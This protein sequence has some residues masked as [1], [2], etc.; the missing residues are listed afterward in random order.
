MKV[1]QYAKK[2]IIRYMIAVLVLSTWAYLTGIVAEAQAPAGHAARSAMDRVVPSKKVAAGQANPPLAERATDRDEGAVPVP[3]VV[4]LQ[5][6]ASA[7]QGRP[8]WLPPIPAPCPMPALPAGGVPDLGA[9]PSY[10]ANGRPILYLTFDD[11]PDPRYTLPILDL[12]DR[13]AARATFFVLGVSVTGH[14]NTMREV[15]SRGHAVG[16]HT[17]DHASLLGMSEELFVDQVMCTRQAVLDAAGDLL[18]P[19]REMRYLRPPMGAIDDDTRRRAAELGMAIV[20][21]DRDVG[22]WREPGAEVIAERLVSGARPGAIVLLHDGGGDRTQTVEALAHALPRWSE[23][24][25]VCR[26]LRLP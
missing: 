25:Y 9:L 22:D 10:T 23:Q 20:L 24:G 2:R 15:A 4:P 11:G 12:L 1:K 16:V 17:W 3:S 26:S 13:H 8:R 14:P 21:W 7:P 19:H 5:L 6:L 18:D